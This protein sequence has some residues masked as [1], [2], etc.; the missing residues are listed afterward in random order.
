MKYFIETRQRTES[1]RL[2][3]ELPFRVAA[4]NRDNVSGGA[5]IRSRRQYTCL[6]K[7]EP[8]KREYIK[9]MKDCHV[10][11]EP[12]VKPPGYIIPHHQLFKNNV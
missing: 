2:V 1:G 6:N 11:M 4:P 7:D 12:T 8:L 3:V 5:L 10:H 9:F